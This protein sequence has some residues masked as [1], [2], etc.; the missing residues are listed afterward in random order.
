[1]SSEKILAIDWGNEK[2]NLCL[3]NDGAIMVLEK[4][5]LEFSPDNIVMYAR[6]YNV[7]TIS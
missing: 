5:S 1:M 2:Q 3:L 4:D 7:E 6:D